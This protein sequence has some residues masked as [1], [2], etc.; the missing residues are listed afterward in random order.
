[1]KT[2]TNDIEKTINAI[3]K[4]IQEENSKILTPS[5][6]S[7]RLQ[8]ALQT[9]VG[10]I[11]KDADP[12]EVIQQ[13]LNII[14]QVPS[15]AGATI[16]EA[17]TRISTRRTELQVWVNVRAQYENYLAEREEEQR[18]AAQTAAEQAQLA[19]DQELSLAARAERVLDDV[20][21]G[22]VKERE[23]GERPRDLG[24]HPGPT[25]RELRAA[26]AKLKQSSS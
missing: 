21:N 22:K 8:K 13:L 18:Q 11:S 26:K 24:T 12:K 23:V 10:G 14:N 3:K 9:S 19:I 4:Q 25:V 15:F 7:S 2:F 16:S 20:A 6:H 1:M 17:L 5:F